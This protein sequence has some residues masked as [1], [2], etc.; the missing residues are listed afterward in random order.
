MTYMTRNTPDDDTLCF[1]KAKERNQRTFTLVQQ[2]RS[3]AKTICFWIMENIETAP[4][5]KLLDALEDAILMR[6][7]EHRKNAD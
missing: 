3:S 2:D 4:A 1:K 7:F 5:Q 6:D